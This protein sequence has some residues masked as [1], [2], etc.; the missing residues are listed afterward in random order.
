MSVLVAVDFVAE[1]D[2]VNCV[3]VFV[4]VLTGVV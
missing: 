2:V 3:A 1:M 4:T